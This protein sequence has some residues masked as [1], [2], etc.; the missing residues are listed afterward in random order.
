MFDGVRARVQILFA[1]TVS[2]LKTIILNNKLIHLSHF[3]TITMSYKFIIIN[4]FSKCLRAKLKSNLFTFF[5]YI[6]LILL[7][8][9]SLR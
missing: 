9:E 6:P 7:S 1:N 8:V 3:Y 2:K 5:Q 4:A